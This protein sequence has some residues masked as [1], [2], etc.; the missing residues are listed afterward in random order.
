MKLRGLFHISLARK[1]QLLFG[2]AVVLII[3]AALFVPGFYLETF[4]HELH[5]RGARQL[6]MLARARLDTTAFDWRDEQVALQEW[7]DVHATEYPETQVLKLPSDVVPRFIKLSPQIDPELA[8][9]QREYLTGCAKVVSRGLDT[10]I[11][12]FDAHVGLPTSWQTAGTLWR[13]TPAVLR[14]QVVDRGRRAAQWVGTALAAS[15]YPPLD[16][17]QQYCVDEMRRDPTITEMADPS[18]QPV[19]STAYRFAIG[20]RGPA[21]G[22]EPGPLLGLVYVALPADELLVFARATIV[23]AGMLAGFLAI[24]VFYLVSQRLILAPVRELKALVEEIGAG[25]VTARANLTTGDEFEELSDAFNDM[26]SRLERTRADL[27]AANRGLDTRLGELAETNVALYESNRL[28]SEF[29]ANVSHEL[30]T[31]LTSII[32]FADL[33]RDSMQGEGS[34]DRGRISRYADNIVS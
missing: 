28:K 2:F 16:D 13:G 14:D 11:A 18:R 10:S 31:P 9:Q 22:S 34:L 3:A 32:G 1:C 8:R 23:L 5:L 27:E 33:L 7:W 4:V 25:D 30:R 15:L 19:A 24:L 26:L 17:W 12:W 21:T 6:A 29:L 20:V